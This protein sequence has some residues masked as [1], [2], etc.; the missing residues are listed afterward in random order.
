MKENVSTLWGM[1]YAGD[2]HIASRIA[3][4]LERMLTVTVTACEAFGLTISEV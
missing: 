2:V 4:E 1:L 3:G